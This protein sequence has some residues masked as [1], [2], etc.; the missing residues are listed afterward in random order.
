MWASAAACSRSCYRAEKLP[1]PFNSVENLR[2]VGRH[3]DP[4]IKLSCVDT[5][6]VSRPLDTATVV[7]RGDLINVVHQELANTAAPSRLGYIY[8]FEIQGPA[9]ANRRP[10]ERVGHHAYEELIVPCEY[11]VGRWGIRE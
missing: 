7:L 9:Q 1:F 11:R 10:E 3:T 8:L 6:A 5:I 4:G 2:R